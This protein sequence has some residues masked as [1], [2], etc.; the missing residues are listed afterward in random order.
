MNIHF[1]LFLSLF[2]LYCM[3]QSCTKGKE[4]KTRQT[5]R[6]ELKIRRTRT[7]SIDTSIEFHSFFFAFPLSLS[8]SPSRCV[9]NYIHTTF[10][11][12]L[13]WLACRRCAACV[14]CHELQQR[15]QSVFFFFFFIGTIDDSLV[16]TT[17]SWYTERI[18]FNGVSPSTRDYSNDTQ[19]CPRCVVRIYRY[20]YT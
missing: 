15:L 19:K 17:S 12:L 18:L 2:R 5:K 20:K 11:F 1:S 13:A 4:K 7:A 8:V 14:W 6:E 9:F 16:V 10:F 3:M